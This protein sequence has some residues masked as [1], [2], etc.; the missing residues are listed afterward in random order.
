MNKLQGEL[1]IIV[2]ACFDDTGG[3]MFN[4]RRQ[5]QDRVLRERIV[6]MTGDASL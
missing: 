5:S 4:R 6:E 3:M 1:S 2:I